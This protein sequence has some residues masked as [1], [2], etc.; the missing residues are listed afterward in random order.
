M[1]ESDSTIQRKKRRWRVT[2]IGRRRRRKG[3]KKT[4]GNDVGASS[5][6]IRTRNCS[7]KSITLWRPLNH[8]A[9]FGRWNPKR[10]NCSESVCD[11]SRLVSPACETKISA[12]KIAINC[13][14]DWMRSTTAWRVSMGL[15][16]QFLINDDD[17]DDELMLNVLRCQLTY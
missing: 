15:L 11:E 17:D 10:Q 9:V 3:N 1:A 12:L 7:R 8:F 14:S 6:E 4:V 16:C 2:E 13:I 5:L